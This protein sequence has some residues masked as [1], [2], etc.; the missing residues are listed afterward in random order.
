MRAR[1]AASGYR[2]AG[3]EGVGVVGLAAARDGSDLGVELLAVL[4]AGVGGSGG[5]LA[6]FFFAHPA[7]INN[8]AE[9]ATRAL[10]NLGYFTFRFPP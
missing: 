1:V 2:D 3:V 4:A 10:A 8:K 5:M 6:A 7:L 9:V